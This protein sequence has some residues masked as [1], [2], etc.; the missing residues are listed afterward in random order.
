MTCIWPLRGCWVIFMCLPL[1]FVQNLRADDLE[2]IKKKWVLKQRP[3]FGVVGRAGEW[4]PFMDSCHWHLW[5]FKFP[6]QWAS[7]CPFV[8][9]T[10]LHVPVSYCCDQTILKLFQFKTTIYYFSLTLSL[11]SCETIKSTQSVAGSLSHGLRMSL[12]LVTNLCIWTWA[13]FS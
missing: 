8:W 4:F 2:K 9:N 11:D 3:V 6:F 7:G 13:D 12:A 5:V 1:P 10:E